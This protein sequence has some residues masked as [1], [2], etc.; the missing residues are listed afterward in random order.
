MKTQGQRPLLN[1]IGTSSFTPSDKQ[2]SSFLLF[3]D[4]SEET[5]L[6]YFRTEKGWKTFQATLLTL[7]IC[8]TSLYI[9]IVAKMKHLS[10]KTCLLH[11]EEMFFLPDNSDFSSKC[12]ALHLLSDKTLIQQKLAL[13]YWV[14][15]YCFIF[16]IVFLLTDWKLK[17]EGFASLFKCVI[18]IKGREK[19]SHFF[20]YN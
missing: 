19:R 17:L 10:L 18:R 11:S 2:H 5:I 13:L 15:F 8:Q 9:K 3:T 20:S 12:N 7:L 6:F 14:L 16:L 1:D 4:C